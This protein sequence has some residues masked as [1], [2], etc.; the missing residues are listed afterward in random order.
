MKN[1]RQ[2][3]H[4]MNA[5]DDRYLEEAAAAKKKAPVMKWVL[6]MA[7]GLCL[8]LGL[9]V[10]FRDRVAPEAGQDEVSLQEQIT[11]Q[12]QIAPP[13]ELPPVTEPVASVEEEPAETGLN[14]AAELLY[15]LAAKGESASTEFTA[16]GAEYVCIAA[17]AAEMQEGLSWRAES[18][19]MNLSVS[20]A[21]TTVS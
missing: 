21:E 13:Q 2:F 9:S 7:A 1:R 6:P 11:L 3:E 20:G 18:L 17:P 4:M 19:S 8:V 5:I 16:N 15:E 12:E 14:E 10:L